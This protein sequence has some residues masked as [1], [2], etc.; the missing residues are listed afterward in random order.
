MHKAEVVHFLMHFGSSVRLRQRMKH[1]FGNMNLPWLGVVPVQ[2]DR[3][4]PVEELIRHGTNYP[5][6][7]GCSLGPLKPAWPTSLLQMLLSLPRGE[8]LLL[9]SYGAAIT[10]KF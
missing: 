7:L 2:W 5:K 8:N 4:A 1:I 9:D 3:V 6:E 10:L